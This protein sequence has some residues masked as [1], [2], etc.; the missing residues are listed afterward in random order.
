MEIKEYEVYADACFRDTAPP[1]GSRCP[2]GLDVR[3]F[4]RQLQKGNYRGAYRAYQKAVLFPQTVSALCTAPCK[5]VCVRARHDRAVELPALEKACIGKIPNLQPTRYARM[6]KAK[7]VAV[8]GGG[9]SGLAF[10]HRMASWGYPVTVYEKQD[11]IGGWAAA[12][13]DR[14]T[15]LAELSREFSILDCQFVTGR[16]ITSLEEIQADG[17]YIA[18]G[19]GGFDF[20][21]RGR[22]GVCIGGQLAGAAPV[23]SL[24]HG[25]QAARCLDNFF[26]SG[27]WE[28]FAPQQTVREPDERYY[29]LEYDYAA[30]LH[31]P[32]KGEEEAGRCMLCSCTACMDVCPVMEKANAYPKRACAEI[33]VTLKPNM[34]RRTGVRLLNNCTFCGKCKEVCPAGVDMER[35]MEEARRDFYDSGALPPA[36]HEYWMEDLK[37]S[38][39]EEACL[40][41]KPGQGRAD[42]LFFPGCQL[43]ASSPE[44]VAGIYEKIA[45]HSEN[46]A[47][48]TGCCGL[49]AKWAGREQEQLAMAAELAAIWEQLGKPLVVTACMSCQANLKRYCP[50]MPLESVYAWLARRPECLPQIQGAWQ[51]LDPCTSAGEP[52][53]QRAVRD[54]LEAMGC[55]VANQEPDAGCCGFGGH[56][57]A[58]DP[59]LFGV[60][61]QRRTRDISEKAVTYC[62]NCRDIFAARGTD[63]AHVLDLV[64]GRQETCQSPE[65]QQRRENRTALKGRYA[66]APGPR[67][68]TGLII[69]RELVEKMDRLLLLRSQVEETVRRCRETGEMVMDD[70]GAYYGHRKFGTV[71]IWC[72]W[73][74][75]DSGQVL[76]AV[77]SHRVEVKE[78]RA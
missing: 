44:T 45:A 32:G 55:Q 31:I 49:P 65:L 61:A 5:N 15:C 60:F 59:E 27:K 36:F 58:V 30:T 29:A 21:A 28:P 3:E 57:Y 71:T 51:V 9:L 20:G 52:Q 6:K 50:E 77:Y 1:C 23:E 19:Q 17:I 47:L 53:S 67:A 7:S 2:F 56:M 64:L 37:H 54:L 26:R 34:S 74:Q 76:T 73:Q 78:G 66:P 8:I 63:C 48:Y 42:V 68:G 62:A 39:S 46:A 12:H 43:G 38:G 22:E 16:E 72:G 70:Q 35:C 69:P 75:T 11:Q 10:A 18:T 41:H 24:L 33:I 40:L 13:M 25:L 14:E 4:V